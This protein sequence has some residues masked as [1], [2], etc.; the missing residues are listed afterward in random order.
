MK[1]KQNQL[2]QAWTLIISVFLIGLFVILS[3]LSWDGWIRQADAALVADS[4]PTTVYQGATVPDWAHI[5]FATL[6][7]VTEAGSIQLPRSLISQLGYDP[8]RS[9]QAGQAP[10]TFMMLGDFGNAFG[11]QQLSLADI[12]QRT[13]GSFDLNNV[14]LADL[15]LMQWQTI[16]D[17]VKAIPDLGNLSVRDVQPILERVMGQGRNVLN[18]RIA[19]IAQQAIFKNLPLGDLDLSQ[20]PLDAI[21]GLMETPLENFQSWQQSFISDVPGL[22]E[23]P[24]AQFPQ[25]PSGYGYVAIL[26]VVY[27][28]KEARRINTISGSD[29]EG[30]HVPCPG[31]SCPYI[32]LTDGNFLGVA[33]N[34]S[35]HGAQWIDGKHTPWVKGGHGVLGAAF[36]GKEPTGRLPYGETPFKVVL[37]QTT[38]S[39]GSAAFGLYFRFCHRGW[40]DLG[41]TPYMFGP[42]PW[43][44]QHEDD[45]IFVG[46]TPG[47]PPP[48]IPTPETPQ[49][50]QD[51]IDQHGGEPDLGEGELGPID[52]EC[53]KRLIG[54]ASA[55]D[56]PSAMT[57]MPHIMQ[58]AQKQGVTDPAQ[59]AYILATAQAETNFRSRDQDSNPGGY[60]TGRGYT[61]LTHEYNYRYFSRKLGIDLMKNPGL[62]NDPRIASEIIVHGMKHGTFTGMTGNGNLIHGG[63]KKLSDY[64]NG[65]KQDF[66]G[67]RRIVND[68]DRMWE[69][70]GYARR[71]LNVLKG[72]SLSGGGGDG[73]STGR[74]ILPARGT[75]TSEMGWRIHPIRGGRRFHAGLDIGAPMGSPAVASD[76]GKVIY[77]DWMGGYGKIVIVDH[78]NGTTTRYGH[79]KEFNVRKGQSVS[80][81]QQVGQVGS[82]GGS[83]GPHLH[84]EVRKNGE[85]VDPR[86]YVKF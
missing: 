69:I 20:H 50:V 46:L 7:A 56:R 10:A 25:P 40:I 30:F 18:E 57:A 24:F 19:E 9:W 65:S 23:T 70:A 80:R 36:G 54:A 82:T 53:L 74:F 43:I 55:G 45:I 51:Y 2:N 27:G 32:E 22:K 15:G 75:V 71:Y 47:S 21:P 3:F 16:G 41:C 72:C 14:S 52:T 13:E 60:E 79:L 73:K 8:S 34:T 17:L 48:G 86:H 39:T 4:I 63:G 44:P 38:E 67:A 77:A 76:G 66:V 6:P 28:P 62:A 33:T 64:I 84:F 78:G 58:A 29:V 31:K 49:E 59:V 1:R 37:T 68:G 61:Q 83:T 85:P 26:D 81:G 42:I 11:L 5:T 35:L 12:Y